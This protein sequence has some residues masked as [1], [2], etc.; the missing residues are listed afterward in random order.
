MLADPR[1]EEE[2]R[3]I[4]IDDQDTAIER[5]VVRAQLKPTRGTSGFTDLIGRSADMRGDPVRDAD[6]GV[7]DR[8]REEL[9]HVSAFGP[10]GQIASTTAATRRPATAVPTP[11][12][13][14]SFEMTRWK[15]EGSDGLSLF[16]VGLPCRRGRP[17]DV[18]LEAPTRG[19]EVELVD[20]PDD[21]ASR[22]REGEQSQDEH[23]LHSAA[24]AESGAMP[25]RS[26][27]DGARHGGG[28]L[29]GDT[30][31]V[32]NQDDRQDEPPWRRG[33]STVLIPAAALYLQEVDRGYSASA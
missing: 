8:D 12:L 32:E 7:E 33:A 19:S 30:G 28:G 3:P 10:E 16:M 17:I 29:K 25:G 2:N 14:E 13:K 26:L 22:S 11:F 31:D 18:A 15:N 4:A 27:F 1:S 23:H 9:D 24:M 6:D 5:A 20:G 21:E